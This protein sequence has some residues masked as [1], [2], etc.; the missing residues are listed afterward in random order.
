LANRLIAS[1]EI[2]ATGSIRS[3][4][5]LPSP[6]SLSEAVQIPKRAGLR[7][8]SGLF[9]WPSAAHRELPSRLRLGCGSL[10]GT[11]LCC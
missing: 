2:K 8:L 1:K 4:W 10:P 6:A 5:P 3:R 9:A 11:Q 7:S